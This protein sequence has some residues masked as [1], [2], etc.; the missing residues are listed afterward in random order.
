M[1]YLIIV[2]YI[3]IYIMYLPNPIEKVGCN[4]KSIFKLSFTGLNSGFS[5]SAAVCHTKVKEISLSYYLPIT[6]ESIVRF[7]LFP[8]V[9]ELCEKQTHPRFELTV[10]QCPFPTMITIT[11]QAHPNVYICIVKHK[12][13]CIYIDY[14]YIEKEGERETF[15]LFCFVF[16]CVFC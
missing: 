2:R 12:H 7:V 5:F 6:V 13:I 4:T 10:L 14:L 1:L 15:F 3:Y 11:P 8:R 16:V 9:L